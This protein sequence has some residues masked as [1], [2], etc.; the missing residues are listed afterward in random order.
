MNFRFGIF[1]SLFSL[2]FSGCGDSEL[3]LYRPTSITPDIIIY[4]DQVTDNHWTA[5]YEKGAR[6]SKD[7]LPFGDT[8][9]LR[10]GAQEDGHTLYI[11]E[12]G[13]ALPT[14]AGQK[15]ETWFAVTKAIDVK[16]LCETHPTEDTGLVLSFE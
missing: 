10:L 2:A 8:I 13:I 1:A 16:V 3:Y 5:R 4:V 12:F 11:P 6:D 15:T 9:H 7:V 14:L